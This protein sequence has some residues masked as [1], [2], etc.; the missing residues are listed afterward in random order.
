MAYRYHSS[1]TAQIRKADHVDSAGRHDLHVH[2]YFNE[3]NSRR[4]MGRYRLPTL[5]PIFPKEPEL[6]RREI[7]FLRDWLGKP[8][9]VRK[10]E[11]FLRETL[12]NMHKIGELVPKYGEIETDVD[13]ETYI[14]IRVPVSRRIQ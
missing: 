11:G 1:Y 7:E 5:E 9:Q 8:E 4:L 13:G 6:G 14:S 12:F 2:L 3:G 10:L